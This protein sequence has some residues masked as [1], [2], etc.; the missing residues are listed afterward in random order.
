MFHLLSLMPCI[1]G[2]KLLNQFVLAVIVYRSV[3]GY[4]NT[5]LSEICMHSSYMIQDL[6]SVND[7]QT[8]EQQL[9]QCDV[10]SNGCCSSLMLF[11]NRY[12]WFTWF[13][14]FFHRYKSSLS[15]WRLKRLVCCES[16]S[17]QCVG[18]CKKQWEDV[19]NGGSMGGQE[20]RSRWEI[21]DLIFL[22]GRKA[23]LW[24]ILHELWAEQ[25]LWLSRW[26]W[27]V[28]LF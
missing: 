11:I 14:L 15:T 6:M 20:S 22:S 17:L 10:T 3:C 7:A 13:F 26:A 8:S 19:E 5:A 18:I 2:G 16:R 28:K 4:W 9:L 23:S 12:T 21:Q 25:Q 27:Y 24:Q 1:D